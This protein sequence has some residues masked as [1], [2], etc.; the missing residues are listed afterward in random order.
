MACIDA[1]ELDVSVE[2]YIK[3]QA[4]GEVG[5]ILLDDEVI[6]RFLDINEVVGFESQCEGDI[7]VEYARG[8]CVVRPSIK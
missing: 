1:I 4:I 5:A 6:L 3:P 8:Y 7:R 2:Q